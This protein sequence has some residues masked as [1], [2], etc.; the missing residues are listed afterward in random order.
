M[1]NL[2][3]Q[4]ILLLML[5]SPAPLLA[6]TP[7]DRTFHGLQAA[8]VG[9]A[10]MDAVT[11][12][13][14]VQRRTCHEANPILRPLVDRHGIRTAM[15]VKLATQGAISGGFFY[16]WKHYPE[17]RKGL[18]LSLATMTA[19]QGYVDYRNYQTLRRHQ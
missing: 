12:S 6:Q 14:C 10:T 3:R 17:H 15:T 5:S 4:V 16:A 2:T 19:L 9:L 11:T 18:L 13:L 8:Y 1:A 7:S